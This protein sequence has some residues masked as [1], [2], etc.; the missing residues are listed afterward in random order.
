MSSSVSHPSL[1][2]HVAPL[3][4]SAHVVAA[5]FLKEAPALALGDG[6]VALMR[7]DGLARIAAHPD[8]GILV[9]AGS[10]DRLVTG[11]DDGRVV[12]IRAD[13]ATQELG[14]AKGG[15]WIDAV[16]DRDPDT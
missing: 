2:D 6:T 16:G 8:S 9:A 15:A 13:G 5:H 1:T 12:E 3:E 7:G 14:A 4:A 10:P 11:G